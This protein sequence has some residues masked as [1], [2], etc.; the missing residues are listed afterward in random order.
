MRT[1]RRISLSLVVL[2]SLAGLAQA[3][4]VELQSGQKLLDSVTEP[5]EPRIF[6][7]EVPGETLMTL[8]IVP[9]KKTDLVPIVDLLG[10]EGRIDLPDPV[11][12]KIK[13]KKLELPETGLYFLTITGGGTTGDYKLALKLKLQKKG[14]IDTVAVPGVIDVDVLRGTLMSVTVKA[15]KGSGVEPGI[16]SITDLTGTDIL[17]PSLLTEKG[18]SAKLKKQL[19]PVFG[20][21]DLS[22]VDRTGTGGNV[23]VTIKLK[24]P[25]PAVKKMGPEDLIDAGVFKLR[26]GDGFAFMAWAEDNVKSAKLVHPD[27]SE[28]DLPQQDTDEFGIE[29]EYGTEGELDAAYPDG[30]YT[31]VVTRL[32]DLVL[33]IPVHLRGDWPGEPEITDE[34]TGNTPTIEW[35]LGV[36][37]P[38]Q[39]LVLTLTTADEEEDDLYQVLLPG[40]DRSH[41]VPPGPIDGDPYEIELWAITGG[42]KVSLPS[43]DGGNGGGSIA[44]VTHSEGWSASAT[45]SAGGPPLHR[46]YFLEARLEGTE[47][48]DVDLRY[49]DGSTVP[50]DLEDGEWRFNDFHDEPAPDGT[51]TFVVTDTN[52]VEDET[53]TFVVGG[54][55]LEFD[56]GL[57]P[58]D[59]DMDTGA[60]PLFTWPT[61]PGDAGFRLEVED[62]T[63]NG[64][65]DMAFAGSGTSSYQVQAGELDADRWYFAN[66]SKDNGNGKRA[67]L[68]SAFYTGSSGKMFWRPVKTHEKEDDDTGGFVE[69]YEFDVFAEV[70]GA[71]TATLVLPDGTTE[72]ALTKEG[73]EFEFFQSYAG[74]VQATLDAAFPDGFYTLKVTMTNGAECPF[75]YFYVGGDWPDFASVVTPA[76]DST[77]VSR[78]PT[79]SWTY[80]S[81]SAVAVTEVSIDSDEDQAREVLFDTGVTSVAWAD[82]DWTFG[83]ELPASSVHD[84]GIS[85]MSAMGKSRRRVTWFTTGP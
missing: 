67:L 76:H 64:V 73:D 45:R 77:G 38:T 34:G 68:Y 28:E 2:V 23:K 20:Q 21:Q 8:T 22:L 13:A 69:F 17:D 41:T 39:L 16:D 49:P 74:D 85:T 56:G 72:H 44:V 6:R 61:D 75:L 50:M 11:K 9:S 1:I 80:G 57:V 66:V 53:H 3:Q 81:L 19:C 65:M 33:T 59:G 37:D 48:K 55:F 26:G 12:G 36:G 14:T 51:Y 58:H 35:T 79:V 4:G 15:E 70:P 42:L 46:F 29:R 63:N 40:A 32:D 10:P 7:F 62:D 5:G 60:T 25:K 47:I 30:V 84:L 52:D 24:F 71:A 27:G 82:F 18:S 31:L 78:T 43:E 54:V 83:S